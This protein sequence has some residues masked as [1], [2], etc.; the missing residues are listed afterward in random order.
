[1]IHTLPCFVSKDKVKGVYGVTKTVNAAELNKQKNPRLS[2][3][4]WSS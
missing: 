2:R 3:L 4:F 1:M